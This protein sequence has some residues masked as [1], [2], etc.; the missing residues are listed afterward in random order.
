M[1]SDPNS[2]LFKILRYIYEELEKIKEELDKTRKDLSAV[3]EKTSSLERYVV[4]IEKE[5]ERAKGYIWNLNARIEGV[6]NELMSEIN[7][8]KEYLEQR[9]ENVRKE[10]KDEI[11]KTKEHLEQRIEKAEQRIENVRKELRNEINETRK[12]LEGKIAETEQRLGARIRETEQRLD[13]HL[14]EQDRVLEIH[15]EG[16]LSSA[17]MQ[18]VGTLMPRLAPSTH[19]VVGQFNSYPLI[20]VEDEDRINLFCVV[21]EENQSVAEQVKRLA[22]LIRR[23][24]GK[25]VDTRIYAMKPREGEP[26]WLLR[27]ALAETLQ[28]VEKK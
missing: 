5:L 6:R 12:Y 24:T 2:I 23:Y 27:P 22:H 20:V 16:L 13:Q 3:Y 25:D 21:K 19:V 15:G 9:I 1:S 26:L 8:T 14:A 7:E 18:L 28:L 4:S 17:I 10:L 11:N